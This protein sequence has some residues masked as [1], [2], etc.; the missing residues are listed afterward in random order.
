MSILINHYWPW[1]AGKLEILLILTPHILVGAAIGSQISSL[2]LAFGA[3][4]I[5]HYILEAF[6]H[7]EYEVS[8]LKDKT[9]R[10][11]ARFFIPLSKVALDFFIG[12][13]I[14]FLLIHNKYFSPFAFAAIA[15]ALA[16]DLLLFL[17]WRF[18]ESSFLKFFAKPHRAFHIFKNKSPVWLDLAV[19]IS[20]T[21]LAVIFLFSLR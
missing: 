19:E 20:V 16:P 4:F 6:P 12:F 1:Q 21:I 3:S 18:P 14:A 15:G 2:P 9:I 17:Y 13:A 7:Y 8:E 5:S 11:S 10:P